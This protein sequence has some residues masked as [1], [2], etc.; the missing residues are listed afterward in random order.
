VT[1][2]IV[3]HQLEDGYPVTDVTVAAMDEAFNG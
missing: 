2:D 1:N 3:K